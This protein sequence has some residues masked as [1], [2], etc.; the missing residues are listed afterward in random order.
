MVC[1]I[2]AYY[3]T[4]EGESFD[5]HFKKV[6]NDKKCKCKECSYDIN[7]DVSQSLDRLPLYNNCSCKKIGS[8]QFNNINYRKKECDH[9]L[10][11]ITENISIQFD[12][13]NQTQIFAENFYRSKNDYYEDGSKQIMQIISCTGDFLGKKGFIVIDVTENKRIVY[14]K[15]D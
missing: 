1:V 14:I 11:E 8:I 6:S 2:K 15:F 3:N 5:N 12:D 10:Y 4:E 9:S 7:S 13:C